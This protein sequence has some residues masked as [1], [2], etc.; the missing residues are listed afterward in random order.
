MDVLDW[1]LWSSVGTVAKSEQTKGLVI[2]QVRNDGGLDSIPGGSAR[3]G[4]RE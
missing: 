3:Y 2:E 1:S 4:D